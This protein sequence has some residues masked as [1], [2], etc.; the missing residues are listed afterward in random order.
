MQT[1][2]EANVDV[3]TTDGF[4]LRVFCIGFTK[5][6]PNQI[7]KTSYAK[8][9]QCRAIR[10]RM[11]EIITREISQI[12]LKETVNKLWVELMEG[13]GIQFLH[14]ALNLQDPR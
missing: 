9:S 13:R 2:I 10:R 11:V 4:L 3:K 8:S 14:V 6:Q 7:K 5:R 12:D 1:L